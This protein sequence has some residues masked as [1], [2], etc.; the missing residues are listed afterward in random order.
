VDAPDI[1]RDGRCR[2]CGGEGGAHTEGC[3]EP[4]GLD[5]ILI[6][7]TETTGL[8]PFASPPADDRIVEI[9]AVLWSITNACII[10]TWSETVHGESNAAEAINRIPVGAM[11]DGVSPS[12][13]HLTLW[14][15][16]ERA[17]VIVA[18]RADFDRAFV[19]VGARAVDVAPFVA[20]WACSKF[21]IPWPQGK[22]GD[23]LVHLALAHGVPVTRAH[24][25]LTDC[26]TLAYLFERVA[27]HGHD[28]RAMLRKALRPKATFQ[29][30]VSYDDREK[31][32]QAGFQWEAASKRWL[33][34]M[35][36][37]DAASLPFK[38][39]QETS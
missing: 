8:G 37:E 34:T 31:A 36:I 11:L 23:G 7:D 15:M 24:R 19:E 12:D 16:A 20:P 30:I 22:P 33:R 18:H 17:D 9:G 38:T 25:A 27:E 26:L 35:A 29:A 10:S 5:T 6:V 13:A 4:S 1:D 3:G 32:K 21:D 28:I 14:N 2:E 39:K